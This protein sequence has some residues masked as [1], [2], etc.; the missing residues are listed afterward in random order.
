[1]KKI[2]RKKKKIKENSSLQG[3]MQSTSAFTDQILLTQNVIH[4]A[5]YSKIQ[6]FLGLWN[7]TDT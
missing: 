6:R 7:Q 2:S 5:T 4:L 3:G 1:M